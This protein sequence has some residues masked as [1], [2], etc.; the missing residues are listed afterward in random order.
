[1]S[2]KFSTKTSAVFECVC[3]CVCV[4]VRALCSCHIRV[5]SLA[6]LPSN[7][8][9]VNFGMLD[10]K[11]KMRRNSINVHK[12]ICAH[13]RRIVFLSN[14]K[15]WTNYDGSTFYINPFLCN[16]NLT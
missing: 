1:M 14:K 16:K 10:G 9:Y 12:N 4:C 11:V 7:Y 3:V 13:L 5:Q 15:L 6:V 8:L 2:F